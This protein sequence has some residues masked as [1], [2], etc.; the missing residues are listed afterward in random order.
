M[1]GSAGV[2]ACDHDPAEASLVGL[3]PLIATLRAKIRRVD[4]EILD[5]VRQQSA[6]GGCSR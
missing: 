6:N 5:A 4:A 3:D 2:S 1:K